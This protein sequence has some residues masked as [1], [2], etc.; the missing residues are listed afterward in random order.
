MVLLH[1]SDGIFRYLHYLFFN[2]K[3]SFSLTFALVCSL[4]QEPFRSVPV[5]WTIH[6]SSPALRLNEYSKNGQFQ[7]VNE[8][9]Q[10]FSRATVIVFPTHSMPVIHF[11]D[12][13]LAS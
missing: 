9:K 6:E 7:L 8:W 12:A 3:N 11:S 10:V 2:L 13:Q 4:L 5:I 1:V